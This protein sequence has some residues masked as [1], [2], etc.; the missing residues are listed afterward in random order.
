MLLLSGCNFPYS[1]EI[2]PPKLDDSLKDCKFFDMHT[3]TRGFIVVRCPNS[4]TSITTTG[5]YPDTT[6]TIDRS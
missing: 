2:K 3:G 1:N 6:I 4:T 5:K